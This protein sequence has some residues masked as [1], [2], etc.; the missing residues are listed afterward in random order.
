MHL[1]ILPIVVT[2]IGIISFTKLNNGILLMGSHNLKPIVA[3]A[4]WA[5]NINNYP[6]S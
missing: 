6:K 5:S 2:R 1:M 4:G 3:C